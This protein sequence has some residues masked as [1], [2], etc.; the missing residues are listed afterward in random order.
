MR[1]RNLGSL[2]VGLTAIGMLLSGCS[3]KTNGPVMV[4]LELRYRIV[5]DRDGTIQAVPQATPL[6]KGDAVRIEIESAGDAAV[7]AF[8]FEDSDGAKVLH[9]VADTADGSSVL[10]AGLARM[11]PTRGAVSVQPDTG[12]LRVV[13]IVALRPLGGL[14]DVAAAGRVDADTWRRAVSPLIEASG[15][16][17]KKVMLTGGPPESVVTSLPNVVRARVPKADGLMVHE[18]VLRTR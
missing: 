16:E 9:P 8:A 4:P 17:G 7:Y 3:R 1:E 10:P 12:A 15:A 14:D 5:L 13:L 11:L 6:Q 18:I 2:L